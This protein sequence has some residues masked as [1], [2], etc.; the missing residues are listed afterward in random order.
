M[1]CPFQINESIRSI[2]SVRKYTFSGL[3]L[4]RQKTK[5]NQTKIK[6]IT[7]VPCQQM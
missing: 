2:I 1:A 7:Y 3:E 6:I 4:F 5:Q